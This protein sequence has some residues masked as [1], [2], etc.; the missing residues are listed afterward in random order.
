[1]LNRIRA[2]LL[3]LTALPLP[4]MAATDTNGDLLKACASAMKGIDY[5][6]KDF[7]E[8]FQTGY[9]LGMVQGMVAGSSFSPKRPFC[10]PDT[11]HVGVGVEVFV[12]WA[13]SHADKM[14]KPATEGIMASHMIEFPCKK[15]D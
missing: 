11:W 13:N 1:M 6:P 10:L 9:C 5:T 8:S 14:D 12:K 4:A 2:L 3:I 15:S 7:D